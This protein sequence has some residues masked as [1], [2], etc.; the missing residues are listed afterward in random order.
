LTMTESTASFFTEPDKLRA[1]LYAHCQGAYIVTG[2]SQFRAS[3]LRIELSRCCLLSVEEF[4]PR[5]AFV[6]PAEGLVVILLPVHRECSQTWAGTRLTS[7]EVVT[8]SAPAGVHGRTEGYCRSAGIC[9]SAAYLLRTGR[10][11]MGRNFAI[12]PGVARWRPASKQLSALTALFGGAM[13]VTG[14]RLSAPANREAAAG[15]EQELSAALAECLSVGPNTT[16]RRSEIGANLM[17][18][19]EEMLH[20]QPDVR[21]SVE[22]VAAHLGISVQMLRACC[23]EQLGIPPARYIRLRRL[24]R[25]Q[26]GLSRRGE[27]V[28]VVRA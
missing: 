24:Q 25:L 18:R 5:I 19:F 11:L 1:S 8:I 14:S 22:E 2:G 10:L 28:A 23:H 6:R 17:A 4:L 16:D 9:C 20:V 15:L 7:G 12:P 21:P 27:R 3:L 13:R 26:H